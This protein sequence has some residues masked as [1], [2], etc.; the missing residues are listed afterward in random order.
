MDDLSLKA[1]TFS[2]RLGDYYP[3][4]YLQSSL[5]FRGCWVPRTLRKA[6]IPGKI[7]RPHS[8]TLVFFGVFIYDI[9]LNFFLMLNSLLVI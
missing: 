4:W 8:N 7:Y 2:F 5:V 3:N 9:Y 6:K 1:R